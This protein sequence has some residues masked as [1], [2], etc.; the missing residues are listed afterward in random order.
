M[1]NSG[2]VGV[3][4]TTVYTFRPVLVSIGGVRAKSRVTVLDFLDSCSVWN[5]FLCP[6]LVISPYDPPN[7]V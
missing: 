7:L 6:R 2:C 1:K 4:E 5:E 3:E